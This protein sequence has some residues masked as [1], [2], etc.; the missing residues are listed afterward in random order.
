MEHLSIDEW[1][2]YKG[3]IVDIQWII[4]RDSLRNNVIA[5]SMQRKEYEGSFKWVFIL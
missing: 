4:Y 3:M 2:Y 5:K 1:N